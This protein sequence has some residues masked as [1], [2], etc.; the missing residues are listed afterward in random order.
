LHSVIGLGILTPNEMS[1][2]HLPDA[3]GSTNVPTT[4]IG[5]GNP[6][7]PGDRKSH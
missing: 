5:R 1:T 2:A 4:D 6:V 3:C 7:G